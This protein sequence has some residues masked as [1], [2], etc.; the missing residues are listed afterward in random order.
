MMR[1]PSKWCQVEIPLER[2][3]NSATNY[4]KEI[5]VGAPSY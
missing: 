1:S 5:T 4:L 3:I 2:M